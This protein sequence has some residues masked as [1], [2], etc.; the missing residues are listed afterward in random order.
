MG[1]RQIILVKQRSRAVCAPERPLLATGVDC[2]YNCTV[3]LVS[4]GHYYV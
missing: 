3:I 2:S 4:S 1:A